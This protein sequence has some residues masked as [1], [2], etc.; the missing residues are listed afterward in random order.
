MLQTFYLMILKYA[1]KLYEKDKYLCKTK[2]FILD[3]LTALLA[4]IFTIFPSKNIVDFVDSL[5]I[6]FGGLCE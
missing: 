4:T 3:T 5:A 6:K 2:Y 1:E